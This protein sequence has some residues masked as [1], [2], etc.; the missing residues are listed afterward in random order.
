MAA[1]VLVVSDLW[2]P[3]PGGAERLIFN[4]ARDL[5]RRGAD[6]YALTGYGPALRFDGPPLL[7]R[8][9]G[10]RDQHADGA[11]VLADAIAQVR[12]DVLLVHH[13]YA[14]E[15][16][17]ELVATGLPMVQVVL[18]NRR[19][20]EAALAVFISR[21]VRDQ[22]DHQPGDLLI[23]PPAYPEDVVAD[24]HRDGIGFVKPIEHKGVALVYQLAEAMPERRFVVLRG[25]WQNIE[26]LRDDLPNV[27]YMEP[28][29]HMATFYGECRLLL[30]PSVSED[31]G[32]VAQEATLN[33][34]PCLASDVGGL[35]ETAAGGVLLPPDDLGAWVA[36]IT[37][38]DDPARYAE[39]AARQAA[40][41]AAAGH[42]TAL[43]ELAAAID[44]LAQQ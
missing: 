24:S 19:I 20:P 39:V 5:Q 35:R 6:V 29:L 12:P 14:Y 41:Y 2:L 21:Y 11:L 43:A 38:L 32:T 28:V 27:A 37:E 33:G 8:A 30:V 3:F 17:A 16:E 36:A 15:F 26:L 31:A 1:R 22:L 7:V 25:E 9:I 42:D 40:A 44:W 18:N 13:F 4:L 10:V 34:L 23:T